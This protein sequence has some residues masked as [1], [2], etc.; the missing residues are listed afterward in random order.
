[1]NPQRRDILVACKQDP[2]QLP[3]VQTVL[4]ALARRYA[5]VVL[6]TSCCAPQTATWLEQTGIEIRRAGPGRIRRGRIGKLLQWI[7]FRRTVGNAL[8]ELGP[9]CPVWIA[10]GDSALALGRRLGRRACV[11]HLHE[12][13]DALPMY[14]RLLRGPAR[15]SGAVVVPEPN[16]A[17]VYRNWYGLARTPAVVP[18]KPWSHPGRRNLPITDPVARERIEGIDP[19]ARILLYQGGIYAHRDIRP[20]ARAVEQIGPTWKLVLLGNDT[21]GFLDRLRQICP[22]LVHIPFVAPPGHLEITSHAHVGIATYDKTSLNRLFC[23]PNKI[24]EYAGFGIPVLAGQNPGLT[25]TIGHWGAGICCD[26]DEP[27]AVAEALQRIDADYADSSRRA[28]A[29]FDAVD[30][31][32]LLDDVLNRLD[33][34]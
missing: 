15:R 7:R 29:M 19:D 27:A 2:S 30:L 28:R 17:A 8:A 18:N 34:A 13:Y 3:P 5:R 12:L 25:G 1:M 22:G 6:V 9:S 11:L 26:A 10:S 4:L 32:A 16:R 14:R 31:P 24:W 20:I 21:G 23:A 33:A